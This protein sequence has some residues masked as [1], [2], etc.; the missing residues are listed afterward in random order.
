MELTFSGTLERRRTLLERALAIAR[1]CEPAALAAVGSYA[2][3]ALNVPATLNERQAIATEALSAA[4]SAGDAVLE[5]WCSYWQAGICLQGGDVCAAQASFGTA[6]EIAQRLRQPTM[7]WAVTF[8]E[9]AHRI[10]LG[11]TAEADRLA[12]LAL[13]L[14]T[15]SGQPDVLAVYSAQMGTIRRMQGRSG[16][17]I[18]FIREVAIAHPG[19][20]AF[21]NALAIFCVDLNRLEEARDVLRPFLEEGAPTFPMDLTWLFMASQRADILAALQLTGQAAALYDVLLPYADQFPFASATGICQV[22][23]YLG[24]LAATVGRHDVADR[25]YEA[26]AASQEGMGAKWCTAN[27]WL[28]WGHHFISRTD[29][30]DPSRARHLLEQALEMSRLH[31]YGHVAETA[32]RLLEDLPPA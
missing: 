18:G 6:C 24:R 9:A 11:D 7:L 3:Q 32:A 10:V 14:G 27:T 30:P 21:A 17:V 5:F 31:G 2:L 16:E 1:R 12:T 13:E 20:P 8:Y 28:E 22:N 26:A 4:R 23:H 19:I 15:A 25:H 29:T